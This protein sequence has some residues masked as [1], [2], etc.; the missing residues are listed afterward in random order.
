MVLD[1]SCFFSKP[2]FPHLD[3]DHLPPSLESL[4]LSELWKVLLLFDGGLLL[5][6]SM[7][8]LPPPQWLMETLSGYE[9]SA[10]RALIPQRK[11]RER[12]PTRREETSQGP[13]VTAPPR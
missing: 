7:L 9:A 10:A 3:K 11:R 5:S 13:D 2:Q 1:G 6:L 4:S 8:G 12:K